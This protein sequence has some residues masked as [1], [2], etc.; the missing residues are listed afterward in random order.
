M[1]KIIYCIIFL[2]FS[3]FIFAQAPGTYFAGGKVYLKGAIFYDKSPLTR[4]YPGAI[5]TM[6]ETSK[7]YFGKENILLINDGTWNENGLGAP[8]TIIDSTRTSNFTIAGLNAPNFY[9]IEFDI[10][11]YNVAINNNAGINVFNQLT[12]LNSL[13]NT[14]FNNTQLVLLDFKIMA[15]T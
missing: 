13:S 12:L 11:T 10:G 1:K 3:T 6:K 5:V 2:F 14:V 8:K 9:D 7:Y 4:V 15:V